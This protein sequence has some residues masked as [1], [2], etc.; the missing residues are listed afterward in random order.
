MSA[1]DPAAYLRRLDLPGPVEATAEGLRQLHVAHL[2]TV[3]FE[4]LDI[5]LRRPIMLDEWRLVDKVV[6][7]RRGGFCYELNGA[8][9]SLLRALGFPVTMLSAGV[10]GEKGFGP[11][12][13][14]ML[15]R[16]DLEEPW[17]CDV[18]FG[19]LFLE[20]L[21]LAVGEVQEQ[22][23]GAYRL[24]PAGEYLVLMRQK[25]EAW[26]PQYRFRR[27]AR[28][29]SE[30]KAMCVYHQ[31]SPASHFTQNRLVSMATAAG[32]VT[33]S[34]A[35][36]I[37]TEHGE[38]REVAVEDEAGYARELR[39]RFGIELGERLSLPA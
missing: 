25:G 1:L 35:R 9:A 18:G 2:R 3:P 17:L 10:F 20:P 15:L 27:T 21:R 11:E 29:L 32:R 37:V 30:Y 22:E 6:G 14:H 4:N 12:F 36:L 33:L 5:H 38:R 26:K 24:D 31:T 13:D 28:A 23:G 16:V 19:D 39:E 8:F 7:Q 34:G